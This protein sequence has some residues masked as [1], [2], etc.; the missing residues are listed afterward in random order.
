VKGTPLYMPNFG[1]VE[2]LMALAAN[3]GVLALLA[4][5]AS[6]WDKP[7]KRLRRGRG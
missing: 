4:V 7:T 5:T 6:R 1:S 2:L 3:A